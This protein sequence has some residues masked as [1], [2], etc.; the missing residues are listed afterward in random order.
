MYSST[1]TLLAL[2]PTEFFVVFISEFSLKKT[3]KMEQQN[4]KIRALERFPMLFV[5]LIRNVTEEHL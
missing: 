5:C 4:H 3:R 2:F 1:E